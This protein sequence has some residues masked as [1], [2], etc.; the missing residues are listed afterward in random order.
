[1]VAPG[2]SRLFFSYVIIS[3]A[4]VG[5]ISVLQYCKYGLL[6]TDLLLGWDSPLYVWMARR[7]LTSGPFYFV[8]VSGYPY[9]YVQLLAFL[10]YITG[11]VVV[12]ERVLPFIFTIV[13]IFANAK[14]TY[15][16]TGNV[17]MAGLAALLTGLSINTLRLYADLNRNL[18]AV[19]LSFVSFLLISDFVN[20]D[21]VNRRSL[22][23]KTYLAT[24]I[25][26]FVI[27]G[28][29]LETFFVLA[30]SSILLGV[31]SRNWKKLFALT[32][33]WAIPTTV[34]LVLFPRLPLS[35]L[36]TTGWF[37]SELTIDKILLWSGG[38]WI[39]LGFLTAGALYLSFRAVRQKD[40]LASMVLF[41]A[42][43]IAFLFI[44]TTQKVIPFS[45][46]YTIRALLI[47]PIPVLFASAVFASATLLKDVFFEI[48]LSSPSERH[49]VRISLMQVAL[50]FT[51]SILVIN[52]TAITTQHYDEFLTPYIPRSG[53]DKI[54]T[55]SQYLRSNG[56]SKPLVVF[57]GEHISW[58][59][60][61]YSSYLRVEIG[62]HYL[63][64]GDI[65]GLLR[66]TV[67]GWHKQI[68]FCNPVLLITPYLYDKEVP[69][70]FARYH[71]GQGIYV[72]PPNSVV[73]Y[74]TSYGPAVTVTSDD[75]TKEVRSE[76]LY[77]DPDDSSLIVLRVVTSCYTSY[78]FENYPL[79]WAFLK[80]E[81]G[82]ALSLPE[83]NPRRFNGT[84]AVEGNDPA[85][86]TEDWSMSQTGTMNIS[87]FFRKEGNASLGIDGFTDSW[88]NLGA[89][90]NPHGTW[91]LQ[92]QLSLAVW[93]KASEKTTFSMTLTDSSG[94]TRTF[95]DIRPDGESA[96]TEW[97]RFA[98]NLGNYTS[99]S[100]SFDLSRVDSV[101]FYVYCDPGKHLSFWIDDPVI[102]DAL[103]TGGAVYKARVL[104]E[105]LITLY[106]WTRC[107]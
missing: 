85:E 33:T 25:V 24:T 43:T 35:Y 102:D 21:S 76:Y 70:C 31:S 20:Q 96:T 87:D 67:P 16:I 82:G 5:A 103:T 66:N 91:G 55:A 59:S 23:S 107:G 34:L 37:T 64:Q 77:V 39:L 18:M 97:K 53:Y 101:D 49:A 44:L 36:H 13:L 52:S 38:S 4:L 86:S 74:E 99:Q 28:T 1:M 45:A 62:E 75:G 15:R 2:R 71:I 89:R 65:S 40:T 8:G 93:A 104:Q 54:S 92:G 12:V 9:L 32:L 81:Q 29:Q 41:W 83:K 42:T 68:M 88:G 51:I 27:A 72:I 73:S 69:Y 84:S 94:N 47:L 46:E 14:I 100:Q 78:T 22:L 26:F 95:W 79:E 60:S 50:V 17:H 63:Y 57:Y 58:F 7:V 11:D 10:G 30:L 80:L 106:F 6:G 98:V 90:Y 19:S 61:L 48:G 105:D 56:M 3:C